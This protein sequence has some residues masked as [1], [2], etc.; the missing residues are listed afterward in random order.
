MNLYLDDDTVE[1]RLIAQLSRAGHAVTVPTDVGLAGAAD[2]DHFIHA[3]QGRLVMLTRNHDDFRDLHR[4]VRAAGGNHPGI[5]TVRFDNDPR[6][7]MKAPDIVRA[8]AK[9]EAAGLP[10]ANELHV[11]NPWR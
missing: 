4:V 11:L 1:H 9:L 2:A 10:I 8:I 7:D 6:R 3:I 5:L